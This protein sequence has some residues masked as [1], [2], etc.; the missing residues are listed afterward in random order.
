MSSENVIIELIVIVVVTK[1]AVAEIVFCA[2]REFQHVGTDLAQFGLQVDFVAEVVIMV[3]GR[4]GI[5]DIA[6]N[7]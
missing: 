1:G 6:Y 4:L 7:G 2:S 5:V 3:A